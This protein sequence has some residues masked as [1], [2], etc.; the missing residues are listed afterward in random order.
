[1]DYC[2]VG[3]G[4]S[5]LTATK[6]LLI[7]QSQRSNPTQAATFARRKSSAAM[8]ENRGIRCLDSPR[9]FVEVKHHTYRRQLQKLA[10]AFF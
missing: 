7:V 3:A 8:P 2:V 6:N 4:S 1:M 10:Q 5:G 9:H